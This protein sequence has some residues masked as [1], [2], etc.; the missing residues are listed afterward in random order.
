MAAIG[1]GEK[2]AV[3]ALIADDMQVG[4]QAVD[5]IDVHYTAQADHIN[6]GVFRVK[7]NAMSQVFRDHGLDP[8]PV[9]ADVTVNFIVRGAEGYARYYTHDHFAFYGQ[10]KAIRLK[11]RLACGYRDI[12]GGI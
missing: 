6:G 11:V 4:D 7:N 10:Y 12:K 2:L 5:G 8:V 1:V 9:P 3:I